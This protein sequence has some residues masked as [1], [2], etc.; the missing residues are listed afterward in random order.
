MMQPSHDV[1]WALPTFLRAAKAVGWLTYTAKGGH[2]PPYGLAAILVFVLAGAA[3][4]AEIPLTRLPPID[5][6]EGATPGGLSTLPTP[7]DR[8]FR[9]PTLGGDPQ[10]GPV[11]SHDLT[12]PAWDGGATVPPPERLPTVVLHDAETGEAMTV[13][14]DGH[15]LDHKPGSFFQKATFTSTYLPPL[16]GGTSAF[17]ITDLETFTTCA[18]PFPKDDWPLLITPGFGVHFFDGPQISD[19]PGQVYD[20]YVDFTWMTTVMERWVSIVGFTPGYFG[21]LNNFSSDSIRFKGKSI[22]RY[23]W[24]PG[25]L[26]FLG[27][28]LFLSR[29]DIYLLPVGGL[30][31]T[32]SDDWRVEAVFPRPKFGKRIRWDGTSED[33]V[34][35]AGEFG[36]DSWA[37]ER[38]NGLNDNMIYRDWRFLLGWERNLPGGAHRR[39]EIGYVFSRSI[40]YTSGNT[41]DVEPPNTFI[42]RAGMS[43]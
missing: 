19:A 38:A 7:N 33:W 35:L 13:V 10:L 43:F 14:E 16:G 27:G 28:V 37:I 34:Y 39:I 22:L 1:G 40:E 41:P 31:W 24:I 23:D 11:A 15:P 32:P 9:P 26:Q 21:D 4:A 5:A 12:N 29:R 17:G 25:K 6:T 30:I 3:V 36:G 20:I 42:I 18:V 2:S 8:I